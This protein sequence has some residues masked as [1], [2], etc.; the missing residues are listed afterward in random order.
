MRLLYFLVIKNSWQLMSVKATL[1][2]I[3]ADTNKFS[4]RTVLPSRFHLNAYKP[5]NTQSR[6]KTWEFFMP[7][8]KIYLLSGHAGL[9]LGLFPVI[10]KHLPLRCF[11][12]W[13]PSIPCL[14]RDNTPP[15]TLYDLEHN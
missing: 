15:P 4:R 8:K 1:V 7:V 10:K 11:I 6:K 2:K 12:H 3:I 14:L 5:K 9:F 13:G